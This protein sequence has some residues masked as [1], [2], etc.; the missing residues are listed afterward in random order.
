MWIKCENV[1]KNFLFTFPFFMT[2]AASQ[3]RFQI[4]WNWWGRWYSCLWPV[5]RLSLPAARPREK[6]SCIVLK[7][8]PQVVGSIPSRV[9]FWGCTNGAVIFES[10]EHFSPARKKEHPPLPLYFVEKIS[11]ARA[12]RC[13][14]IIRRYPILYM[15]KQS[16]KRAKSLSSL[17][18]Y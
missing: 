8:Y 12:P 1:G 10:R 14:W 3:F 18:S 5:P 16:I 11:A 15:G 4:W 2:A 9:Y 7:T 13:N 17:A 6:L